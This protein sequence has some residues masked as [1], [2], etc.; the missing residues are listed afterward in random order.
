MSTSDVVPAPVRHAVSASAPAGAIAALPSLGIGHN[1]RLHVNTASFAALLVEVERRLA[2]GKGFTVA[3]LNLDHLVKLRRDPAFRDAYAATSLVVADGN[4]V[5]WLTRLQGLGVG[6]VPGSELVEPLCA[7]AAR[8]GVPVA[9][10]G[11]TQAALDAAASQLEAR[12]PGLRVVLR[13]APPFGYDPD[14][15]AAA[16]DIDRIGRSGARLCFVA[17]GAPK[18]ERLAVR[19]ARALPGCGFVSVGAG[20]DFIAGT[21]SRAPVWMRRLSMEWIWR[22]VSNPRRLAGRYAACIA[23]LPALVVDSLRMRFAGH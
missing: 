16:E 9:M 3:T 13:H 4:P 10:I 22:L 14:G 2:D 8:L 15:A 19:A 1:R 18:Q 11:A 6:L 20:L 5:V 7:M 23:I 12:H 17:L 21:Q